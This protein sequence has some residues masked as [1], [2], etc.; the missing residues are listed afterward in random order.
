MLRCVH[1]GS[2]L[3]A[4]SRINRFLGVHECFPVCALGAEWYDRYTWRSAP[5]VYLRESLAGEVEAQRARLVRRV[6]GWHEDYRQ[7]VTG[8]PVGQS[9]PAGVLGEDSGTP[10]GS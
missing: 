1:C 6:V 9:A 10:V 4:I 2:E 5:D 8:G 3:G 7:Y